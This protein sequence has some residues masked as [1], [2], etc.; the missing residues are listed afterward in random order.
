M[1]AAVVTPNTA[2]PRTLVRQIQSYLEDSDSHDLHL[3]WLSRAYHSGGRSSDRFASVLRDEVEATLADLPEQP[4]LRIHRGRL[5]LD[6]ESHATH[7]SEDIG[8]ARRFGPHIQTI[9]IARDQV[10]WVATL[11]RRISWPG[12]REISLK[13]AT[14]LP[15]EITSILTRHAGRIRRPFNR[16]YPT[17]IAL[18]AELE[19][20]E[21]PAA[22]IQFCGLI[23]TALDA[24]PRW[25]RFTQAS[26]THYA[27]RLGNLVIDLT[28]RQFFPDADPVHV[29]PFWSACSQWSRHYHITRSS[30]STEA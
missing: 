18:V 22:L 2:D 1:S 25:L 6:D 9:E 16:C 13:A 23:P 5:T 28:R 4:L 10:D 19:A 8:V 27:V 26:W 14:L 3:G 15:A 17:S 7:W 20:A 21:Q 29:E 30:I 12:E 11:I 24:D